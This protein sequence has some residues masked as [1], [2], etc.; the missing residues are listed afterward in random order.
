MAWGKVFIGTVR[1][2]FERVSKLGFVVLAGSDLF[3]L[4]SGKNVKKVTK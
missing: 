1:N 2:R 4:G 3:E